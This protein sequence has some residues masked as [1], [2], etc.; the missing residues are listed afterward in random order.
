MKD[1]FQNLMVGLMFSLAAIVCLNAIYIP[2]SWSATAEIRALWI[3][4]ESQFN[5]DPE[6]G[7]LEIHQFIERI[8]NANFNLILPWVRSEYVSALTD[9]AYQKSIPIAKW[10]AL[11]ELIKAA[12]EKGLQVHLWYSFTYYKSPNSP[13]FNPRHG[14]NSEWAARQMNELVPD[15]STGKAVPRRMANVCPLHSEAREWEVNLIRGVLD[16]YPLLSGVHIEEPGY[17]GV[18]NC[19]C[20]LCLKLF[21]SI[22]G[23]DE[24][25]DVNGP[26]AQ[27]LKCVGTTAF[28]RQLRVWLKEKN[29]NLVLSTNGGPSWQSD[30]E[31]GRDWKH[32]AQRGWLDFYAAQIYTTNAENFKAGAQTVIADLGKDCLVSIGVA[33]QWSGGKNTAET[34]VKEIEIA[35]KLGAKGVLIFSGQALTDEYL[36]A[37][38]EGPF[39][40]AATMPVRTQ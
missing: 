4:P 5:A 33:V 9:E 10:D 31:S 6:M 38:K 20:N 21:K 34:V 35:R 22:Y 8:A 11:G 32:W 27:D 40:Q 12:Q 1:F 19:V 25:V 18:G 7:R 24:T 28:M 37:L 17:S 26:Q 2:D 39:K 3:H 23:F 16:R 14:G 30:R 36:T 13:D 15:R 29:P